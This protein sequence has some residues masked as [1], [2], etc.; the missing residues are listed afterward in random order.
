VTRPLALT[1]TGV[2]LHTGAPARVVL[3][4]C[5]GPVRLRAHGD[6]AR[7]DELEVAST[8]RATTVRLAGG[9]LRVATVEHAFAA[10]AGM[11]IY[12]GVT[13]D[14]DGPEMPL[15]DGGA[16]AW[17][18]A[19]AE[20]VAG[21]AGPRLRVSHAAVIEAGSSRF[22]FT[23]GGEGI[24]VEVRLELDDPRVAPT[25]RWRGDPG[26]FRAR[27][28]PARTFA[29][30]RDVE[31]LARAN[32]ARHVPPSSVVL[33]APDSVHCA[34]PPFAADEPARHK[35]LDLV[36]DLYLYGG[37]PLGRVHAIRPGH[38]ANAQAFRR[39][40]ES[41]VLAELRP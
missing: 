37:P 24:D 39:A 40:R 33:L 23:P 41:G 34:G 2:G 5:E 36:G 27:I 6:D 3:S 21:G 19:L 7:V 1:L 32:L 35:L 10:L 22:E 4:R 18:D 25:A 28:A 13:L 16:R 15:L 30:A 9:S 11:G 8:L 20:L 31:E 38:A 26:D 29:L 17:C 14:V 12:D